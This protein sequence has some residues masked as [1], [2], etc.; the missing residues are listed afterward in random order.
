MFHE[1]A[2]SMISMI[3]E[4]ASTSEMSEP[5]KFHSTLDFLQFIIEGIFLTQLGKNE[6]RAK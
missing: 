6:I 3:M 4:V 2:A 5:L 1:L